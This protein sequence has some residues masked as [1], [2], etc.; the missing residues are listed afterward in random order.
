MLQ[1]DHVIMS[2]TSVAL[3]HTVYI[4]GLFEITYSVELL[5]IYMAASFKGRWPKEGRPPLER[6]LRHRDWIIFEL[7]TCLPF[8][9]PPALSGLGVLVLVAASLISIKLLSWILSP[10]Q[11]QR[12]SSILLT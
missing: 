1:C 2:M 11:H 10:G 3:I 9:V 12:N 4:S 6:P 8:C 7:P 5:V